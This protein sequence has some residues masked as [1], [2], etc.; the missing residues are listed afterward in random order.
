MGSVN[1][2]TLYDPASMVEIK[3]AFYDVWNTIT[4]HSPLRDRAHDLDFKAEIIQQLLDLVAEGKTS[5]HE[6]K[7]LV[8]K[9]LLNCRGVEMDFSG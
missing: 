9:N 7:A 1:H 5:R 2:P 3:A 6:L 8:I 4:L